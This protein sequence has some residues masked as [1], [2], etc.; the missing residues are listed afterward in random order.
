MNVKY[1]SCVQKFNMNITDVW[2]KFIL[3]GVTFI[4]TTFSYLNC[5]TYFIKNNYCLIV[6]AFDKTVFQ[7]NFTEAEYKFNINKH[8]LFLTHTPENKTYYRF[9]FIEIHLM[10]LVLLRI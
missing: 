2:R 6:D 10:V 3:A 5:K 1:L 9:T 4:C 8:T 7:I